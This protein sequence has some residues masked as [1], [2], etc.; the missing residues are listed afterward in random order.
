MFVLLHV[1]G[2]VTNG[3][4]REGSFG[5]VCINTGVYP[6]MCRVCLK[7]ILEKLIFQVLLLRVNG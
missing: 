3:K 1:P 7:L 5:P 4:G 6:S 2:S